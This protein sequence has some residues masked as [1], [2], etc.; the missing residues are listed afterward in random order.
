MEVT[1]KIGEEFNLE[2]YL[3]MRI[4]NLFRTIQASLQRKRDKNNNTLR[5]VSR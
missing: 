3:Q 1:R 2:P 5:E 4:E